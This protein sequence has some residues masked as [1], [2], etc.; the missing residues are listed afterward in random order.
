MEIVESCSLLLSN[1]EVL[2][3]LRNNIISKKQTNLAT[4]LYETTSYLESS[5][6]VNCSSTNITQFLDIIKERKY[7]LSKMEKIQLVNLQPQNETELHLIV[8]NIEEK[9]T[10]EQRNDLLELVQVILNK[11]Q[12]KEEEEEEDIDMIRK[13]LKLK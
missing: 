1:R 6:A 8:D 3:L 2:D 9:L 13:K 10:D 4:I 7:N 12:V 5:P 11:P